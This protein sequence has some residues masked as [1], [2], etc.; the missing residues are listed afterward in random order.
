MTPG[1]TQ[2]VTTIQER[3]QRA[4]ILLFWILLGCLAVWRGVRG[5]W[6]APLYVL[7]AVG[8]AYMLVRTALVMRKA[9]PAWG[10]PGFIAA[11]LV[12]TSVAVRLLSGVQTDFYLA[13][14]LVLGESAVT[15][16]LPLVVAT[17]AGIAAGYVWATWPAIAGAEW[18]V[19]VSRLFFLLLAGV[20]AAWAATRERAQRVEM[21]RLT[22]ELYLEEERRRIAREIHDGVGHV[23]AAGSQSLQLAER[24]LPTDPGRAGALL[25]EIRALLGQGLDEIRLL[26]LGLRP[27]GPHSGDAVTAV[28]QHLD[29]L[30]A[31]TDVRTEIRC[32]EP[33]LPL[34]PES[35]FALRRIL[36][37]ALTN[38]ARHARA[39]SVT[40]TL[41]R[42]GSTIACSVTD[43]G[44][45]LPRGPEDK[46]GVGLQHMRER[47]EELGG[48]LNIDSP[49]GRGTTVRFTLPANGAARS[50]DAGHG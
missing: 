11:D 40:V 18:E 34:G 13:Y 30:A 37:E 12:L 17:G 42:T 45:G 2:G 36:Q 24:L 22:H 33:A 27:G 31:R 7:A 15:V 14:L 35:E 23:L 41:S 9:L 50:A 32:E 16:Q 8:A 49:A 29:T 4:A 47:A 20:G 39:G 6:P 44:V 48:T 10:E 25:P 38:V 5:P 19:V 28:R 43:D 26:V 21:E 1:I 46:T 3:R